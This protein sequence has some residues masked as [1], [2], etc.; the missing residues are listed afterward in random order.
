MKLT[1]LQSLVCDRCSEIIGF[2]AP[3]S[4]SSFPKG[5]RSSIVRRPPLLSQRVHPL[6]SFVSPSECTHHT[7]PAHS[8]RA[9]PLGSL[10]PLRHQRGEST[11]ASVPSSLRSA[12]RVSHPLDGFLLAPPCGSIS[13]RSHI[14]GSLFR[15][16][17]SAAAAPPRRGP[18]PSG[19]FT[20][21]PASLAQGA[22]S[23]APAPGP[24]SASESVAP[25]EVLP[26]LQR[27]IPS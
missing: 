4:P 21:P 23:P 20:A 3:A 7:R 9:P 17:P 26:P 2:P 12:L 25:P 1:T 27:S 24:C 8:S 14:R 15:G 6:V 19:R 11:L 22:G 13:P 16:F 18:L 5:P 10:P